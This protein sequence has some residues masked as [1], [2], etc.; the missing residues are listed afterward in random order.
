MIF[1]TCVFERN[2]WV[3]RSGF[4]V[5]ILEGRCKQFFDLLDLSVSERLAKICQ[6]GGGF[7]VFSFYFKYIE[8]R[9]LLLCG[10]LYV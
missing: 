4:Y 2:V 9:E 6:Y 5:H 1:V 8:A 3:V 7:L 10:D